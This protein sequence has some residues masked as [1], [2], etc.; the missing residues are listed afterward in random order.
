M[1]TTIRQLFRRIAADTAEAAPRIPNAIDA[2]GAL[3]HAGRALHRLAEAGL[4][5]RAGGSRDLLT[6]DLGT[7]CRAAAHQSGLV[8]GGGGGELTTCMGAAADLAGRAAFQLGRAERWAMSVEF[9]TAADRCAALAQ[10]VFQHSAA[11][12]LS[13]VHRLAALVEQTAAAHPPSALGRAA[14]DRLVPTTELRPAWAGTQVAAEAAAALVAAID[15]ADDRGGLSLREM[16]TITATA[17]VVSAYS[18]AVVA[19]LP[20]DVGE[21]PWRSTAVA[22]YVARASTEKFDDGRTNRA[23]DDTDIVRAAQLIQAAIRYDLGPVT[24]LDRAA[25]HA[26]PDLPHVLDELRLVTNQ[27]PVLAGQLGTMAR[28]WAG[29]GSLHAAARDLPVIDDI[30]HMRIRKII[31]DERIRASGPDLSDMRKAIHRAGALST[32]LADALNR[33]ADAGPPSQPH[34]AALYASHVNT[35][36]AEQQLLAAAQETAHALTATRAPFQA[37]TPR[38]DGPSPGR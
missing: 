34:L 19:V 4:D 30:P 17:E 16:R 14:L 32:G 37:T 23:A 13:G 29:D 7:A 35:P 27:T 20:P 25:L 10:Q 31:A 28:R 36:R 11:D 38:P 12:E 22:W 8:F 2:I 33:T 9:A 3:D 21:K 18:A 1:S 24:E 15:R 5:E 26:R 6:A